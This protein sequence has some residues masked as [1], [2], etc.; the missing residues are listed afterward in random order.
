MLLALSWQKIKT[1]TIAKRCNDRILKNVVSMHKR[2]QTS[3]LRYGFD[4]IHKH[5]LKMN[6]YHYERLI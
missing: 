1:N 6:N 3:S 4:Q 5:S 2:A